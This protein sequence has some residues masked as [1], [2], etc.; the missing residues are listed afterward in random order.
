MLPYIDSKLPWHATFAKTCVSFMTQI[1]GSWSVSELHLNETMQKRLS[2]WV[3]ISNKTGTTMTHYF[4]YYWSITHPVYSI[5]QLGTRLKPCS[6]TFT[7]SRK[8]WSFSD[9]QELLWSWPL[10]INTKHGFLWLS[11]CCKPQYL[12]Y[13]WHYFLKSQIRLLKVCVCKLFPPECKLS[14]DLTL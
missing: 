11:F 2:K 4:S 7:S 3:K 6:R 9:S 12:I 8:P 14:N 1:N 5:N 13:G 10:V